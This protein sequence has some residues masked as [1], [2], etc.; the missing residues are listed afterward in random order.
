MIA[1]S[2]AQRPRNSELIIFEI[3]GGL[4]DPAAPE[5]K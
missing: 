4:D 1:T 3:V 2:L 5:R